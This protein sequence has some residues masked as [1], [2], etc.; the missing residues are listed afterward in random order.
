MGIRNPYQG[1]YIPIIERYVSVLM[2]CDAYIG[3]ELELGSLRAKLGFTVFPVDRKRKSGA[4]ST[5][6]GLPPILRRLI[7]NGT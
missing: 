1:I 3:L 5:G 4:S 7:Q 2:M 6:D